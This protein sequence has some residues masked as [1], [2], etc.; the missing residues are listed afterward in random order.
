MIF[1]WENSRTPHV[2]LLI[3]FWRMNKKVNPNV[4]LFS[5]VLFLSLILIEIVL[6]LFVQPSELSAGRFLGK[7]L[8][9]MKLLPISANSGDEKRNAL[10]NESYK[11]LIVEG[12]RITRG[13]LWGI[14]REDEFLG[15]APKE[16]AVSVNRWWQ[17]NDLGARSRHAISPIKS[18][19]KERILFFGDSLTH[20]SRVP[21]EETVVFY[22]NE[23]ASHIEAINFGV[24][25]YSMG[26]AYLRFRTVKDKIEYDRVFLIFVPTFDLWRDINVNRY[27][28]AGWRSYK[29]NPRFVIE[30]EELKLVQSPYKNLRELLDDNRPFLKPRLR[31][32]LRKYDRFYFR[33]KYETTPI[34]DMSI[35]F[36]LSKLWWS[37]R[38]EAFLWKNLKS[39]DSEAMQ[40]TT[41]IV[42]SMAREVSEKGGQFS[43]IVL[44]EVEDVRRYSIDSDYKN[45]WD[46][47]TSIICKGVITC[48][49]FMKNFKDVSVQTLDKGYDGS[50]YGP[51][52]NKLIADLIWKRAIQ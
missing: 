15:H 3:R 26:Q 16:D 18:P 10:W 39:P 32:H 28:G 25:G 47:M 42:K 44:P 27:I 12:K 5:L 8:P 29:I 2:F 1:R 11:S 50:H 22:L 41:K 23:K 14:L 6:H 19:S 51:S 37:K 17:S 33:S 4:V 48:F 52:T 7:E 38:K 35:M 40:V 9:P 49:D 20:G 21:Q 43:L 24:D 13:D 30:N 31:N 34:L 45:M 36:K 46:E